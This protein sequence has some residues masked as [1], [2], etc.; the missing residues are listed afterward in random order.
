[1]INKKNYSVIIGTRIVFVLKNTTF[2]SQK[3]IIKV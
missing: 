2:L 3:G 1:M